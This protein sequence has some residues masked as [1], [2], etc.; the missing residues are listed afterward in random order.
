MNPLPSLLR[1]AGLTQ[2]GFSRAVAELCREAGLEVSGD[3]AIHRNT[4]GHW[5]RTPAQ[6]SPGYRLAV[7]LAY[8][9]AGTNSGHAALE[10]EERE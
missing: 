2:A 5:C 3:E 1:E 7:A 9:L 4:V 8:L 10:Q 6:G